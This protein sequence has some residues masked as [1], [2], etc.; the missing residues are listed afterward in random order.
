MMFNHHQRAATIAAHA[1]V[2]LP[3]ADL[4]VVDSRLSTTPGCPATSC[5]RSFTSRPHQRSLRQRN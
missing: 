3:L 4:H 5:L 2:N 1:S